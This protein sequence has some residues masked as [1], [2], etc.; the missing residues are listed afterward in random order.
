MIKNFD[1]CDAMGAYID[2]Q[3]YGSFLVSDIDFLG[4]YV[5]K[6][7]AGDIFL[8]IGTQYGKS[9]A[10]AIWQA[11][12][13]VIFYTC[14]IEDFPQPDPTRLSRSKFFESEGL[15]EVCTFIK[16][17][18]LEIARNWKH[19]LLSMIFIDAEHTYEAV[20]QD[21]IAWIPYLKS[22]GFIAFHDYA[23]SQFTV[24]GAIDKYIKN[25]EDFT[26]FKCA[27]EN[28]Y[29]NSSMAGAVKK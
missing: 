23:D 10:A 27:K 13:G 17:N 19:G 28:G 24:M 26:H 12:E 29:M 2:A 1:T 16:G 8:E 11:P 7:E 14:D 25:S 3:I 6:L 15:N 18:S 20:E 9:T 21:M 5:K 4:S 22:G